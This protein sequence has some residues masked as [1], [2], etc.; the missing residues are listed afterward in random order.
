MI[1]TGELYLDCVMHDLRK[2]C[3]CFWGTDD[4]YV[5]EYLQ[6]IIHATPSCEMY[7]GIEIKVSDPVVPCLFWRIQPHLSFAST[8]VLCVWTSVTLEK[9]KNRKFSSCAACFCETVTDTSQ[10]QCFAETPNKKNQLKRDK[11]QTSREFLRCVVRI[12]TGHSYSNIITGSI[13]VSQIC[14]T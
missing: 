14:V 11:P 5:T 3:P 1:G 12:N 13:I 8:R 4:C 6:W 10:I 7:S 9:S 2:V